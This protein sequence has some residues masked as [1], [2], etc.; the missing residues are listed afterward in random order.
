MDGGKLVM[1]SSKKK[2]A[3]RSIKRRLR[4][5]LNITCEFQ[6]KTPPGQDKSQMM[7]TAERKRH[8][9]AGKEK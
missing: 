2:L 7:L 4:K 3:V 6:Q 1:P 5:N 9:E 8:G